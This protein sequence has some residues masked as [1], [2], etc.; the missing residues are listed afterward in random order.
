MR[1]RE[2]TRMAL[3]G[4]ALTTQEMYFWPE[5]ILQ[6][7]SWYVAILIENSPRNILGSKDS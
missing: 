2:R 4:F 7:L 6:C 3:M 1:V 5:A